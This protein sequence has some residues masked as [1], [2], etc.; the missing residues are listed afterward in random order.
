MGAPKFKAEHDA[1]AVLDMQD[2]APAPGATPLPVPKPTPAPSGTPMPPGSQSPAPIST[3]STPGSS[4]WERALR[5]I[6]GMTR[7]L[8]RLNVDA[9]EGEIDPALAECL[10]A[11]SSSARSIRCVESRANSSEDRIVSLLLSN[12]NKSA[13]EYEAVMGV[14]SRLTHHRTIDAYVERMLHLIAPPGERAKAKSAGRI[15][16]DALRKARQFANDGEDSHADL[17]A[18]LDKSLPRNT[19]ETIA[20]DL[21]ACTRWG[22]MM[23]LVNNSTN[24]SATSNRGMFYAM[25]DTSGWAFSYDSADADEADVWP[26]DSATMRALCQTIASA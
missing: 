7:G 14:A 13:V 9:S 26:A 15:P 3:P 18:L 12:D 4:L 6:K 25:S 23:H 5:V 8:Y 2:T 11:F 20:S 24:E 19:A 21:I 17:C 16:G 1:A 10:L 22:N